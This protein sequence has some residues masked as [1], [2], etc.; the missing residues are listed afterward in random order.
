[1]EW[2][3]IVTVLLM[4]Q[5]TLFGVQVGMMRGRHE[6]KAPA[7]SGPPE[8][9]RMYRVHY[10]TMEQLVMLL[11]LMWLFAH[12]VNPVWA[13]G[14]GAVFLAGRFVY[15]SAYLKDPTGRALGFNLTFLPSAVMGVWLLVDAV[16]DLL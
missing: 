11:P 15:R 10:N 8:F 13:A 9:E 12:R 14:F 1:M 3:V 5:Y 16:R 7:M 6:I 2:V 4:F